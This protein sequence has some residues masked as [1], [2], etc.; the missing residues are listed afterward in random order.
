MLLLFRTEDPGSL[1][2]AHHR[3]IQEAGCYSGWWRGDGLQRNIRS[4]GVT[5]EMRKA[6]ISALDIGNECK[7]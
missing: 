4:D 6:S 3:W 7:S 5:G 1:G 2:Y